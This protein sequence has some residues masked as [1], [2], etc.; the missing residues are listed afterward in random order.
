VSLDAAD[1]LR[2]APIHCDGRLEVGVGAEQAAIDGVVDGRVQRSQTAA[3]L[4]EVNELVEKG[5]LDEARRRLADREQA[6][7]DAGASAQAAAPAGRQSDVDKDFKSQAASISSATRALSKPS[8]TA[9]PRLVRR[10][11]E[12]ANP[13]ME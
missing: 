12:S 10:N 9:V 11:Q 13:F 5:R 2:G 4:L 6:L 7:A 3:T 8:P 1:T